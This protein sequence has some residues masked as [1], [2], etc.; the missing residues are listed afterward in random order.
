MSK[1]ARAII[2][3]DGKILVMYRNK[4]GS[5]YFTLVGGRINDNESTEQGMERE[6]YEETGLSVLRSRLVYI[7]EHSKPYNQQYM[8]LCDVAPHGE[9]K[10]QDYSEEAL[11]NKLDANIHR[12]AWVDVKNFSK[13][14]FRTPQLQ[15]AIVAGL[16]NGFP[17]EPIHL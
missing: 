7:E 13:L 11:M 3:E 9:V 4:H 8:Y 17:T 12:P 14:A 5:E 10:I 6:L 15:K 1:A 16:K 2:I